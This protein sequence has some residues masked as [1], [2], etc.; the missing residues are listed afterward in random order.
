MSCLRN[1][2][3]MKI[4]TQRKS[5]WKQKWFLFRRGFYHFTTFYYCRL[6]L[7]KWWLAVDHEFLLFLCVLWCLRGCIAIGGGFTDFTFQYVKMCFKIS[8]K[9]NPKHFFHLF[10]SQLNYWPSFHCW[11]FYSLLKFKSFLFQPLVRFGFCQ[12]RHNHLFY[13][14]GVA[15]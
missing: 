2:S 13:P 12:F 14:P 10:S 8:F 7:L 3:Q 6:F 9:F 11:I 4:C 5:E 15:R 1:V